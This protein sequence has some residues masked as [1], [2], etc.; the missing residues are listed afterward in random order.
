MVAPGAGGSAMDESL[1]QAAS[2][3]MNHYKYA[4]PYCGQHIEYTDGYAGRQMPCPM[5][6]HPILFPAV[7][8][9]MRKSSLRLVGQVDKP[10]AK[11]GFSFASFF[12]ALR[13]FEHWRIVGTCLVPFVLVSGALVAASVLR[14]RQPAPE[15]AP[16]EVT[17]NPQALRQLTELTR[18]DMAVQEQVKLVNNAFGVCQAANQKLAAMQKQHPS[19]PG[20]AL[21]VREADEASNR[22][23]Q[24][25]A[26]AR[27]GFETIFA[28]Y[29]KLGGTVDYRRQLP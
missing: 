20:A 21:G 22:A 27:K 10:A 24:A 3:D 28:N 23:R 25:L 11:T 9:G 29:Q 2:C 1:W 14:Q 18:A 6:H 12:Q 16:T 17:V 19:S 8:A 26:D 7:P 5:C 13:K 15:T 4:C